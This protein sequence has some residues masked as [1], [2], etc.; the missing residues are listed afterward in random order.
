MI[1]KKMDKWELEYQTEEDARTIE[2]YNEIMNDKTRLDRALKQA[3]K[4]IDNLKERAAA[5]SKS[6]TGLKPKKK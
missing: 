1:A 5:L 6:V 4:T 2:R 3:E